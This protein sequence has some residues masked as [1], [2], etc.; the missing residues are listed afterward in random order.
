MAN[1]M[2][3]HST[4]VKVSS[5]LLL[6]VKKSATLINIEDPKSRN[7]QHN[8]MARPHL[9]ADVSNFETTPFHGHGAKAWAE[10]SQDWDPHLLALPTLIVVRGVAM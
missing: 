3:S 9:R 6:T 8:E 7:C 5:L 2:R 10:M 4:M 1:E